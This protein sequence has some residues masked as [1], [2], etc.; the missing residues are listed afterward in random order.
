MKSSGCKSRP[1]KAEQAGRKPLFAIVRAGHFAIPSSRVVSLRQFA[2]AWADANTVRRCSLTPHTLQISPVC[3]ASGE[4]P[5]G[6]LELRGIPAESLGGFPESGEWVMF[7]CTKTLTGLE[8]TGVAV[9]SVSGLFAHTSYA[10]LIAATK[11][12]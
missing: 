3:L 1:V 8:Q 2:C 4:A 12:P 9:M 6:T 10:Y 11:G 7:E 5:L